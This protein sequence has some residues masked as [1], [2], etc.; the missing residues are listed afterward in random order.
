MK[1]MLIGPGGGHSMSS[2][3]SGMIG[4]RTASARLTSRRQLAD[5]EYFLVTHDSM[6]Y[7]CEGGA[8][9]MK[10]FVHFGIIKA[11]HIPRSRDVYHQFIQIL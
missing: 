3:R 11:W 9:E 6:T 5:R 2:S 4:L 7:G 1:T 8:C 10:D